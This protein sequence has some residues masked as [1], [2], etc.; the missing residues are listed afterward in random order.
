M[1]KRI[2]AIIGVACFALFGIWYSIKFNNSVNENV[3]KDTT[4]DSGNNEINDT[5]ETEIVTESS[6]EE[7]TENVTYI[8]YIT[9]AVQNPGVYEIDKDSR[10]NDVLIKAGGATDDANLEI[11]NLAAYVEDAQQIIIPKIGDTVDKIENAIQNNNENIKVGNSNSN[12]NSLININSASKELLT[13]L[14][15]IGNTIADSIIEYRENNGGFKS[16][17]EIKNVPRIGDKTFE[18]LKDLITL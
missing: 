12:G 5:T 7:T 15:G 17:E 9:G 14:P 13:T 10:I 6:V 18:K 8:V 2:Y 11:V 4:I 1:K 16:I 3:W